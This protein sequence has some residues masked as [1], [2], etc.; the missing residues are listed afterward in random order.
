MQKLESLGEPLEDA[1]DLIPEV[2]FLSDVG[3]IVW[4]D[5]C[6][7][8]GKEASSLKYIFKHRVKTPFTKKV[9]E[10]IAGVDDDEFDKA[11]PGIKL[12]PGTPRFKTMLGTPHG[13]GIVH[14]I[15]K[16]PTELSGKTIELIHMFTTDD[17]Y[18]YHLLFILTG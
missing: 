7:K 9:M 3:W 16:H 5:Q 1:G 13:K 6:D 11:W 12:A 17:G 8:Q 15:T 4:A 2:Q 18:N 14:L 10:A